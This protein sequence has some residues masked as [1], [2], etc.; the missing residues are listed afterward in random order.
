MLNVIIFR[1]WCIYIVDRVGLHNLLH[2][3]ITLTQGI[4][5]HYQ[6]EGGKS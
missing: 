4:Q 5:E 3:T 2:L 1:G 6:K